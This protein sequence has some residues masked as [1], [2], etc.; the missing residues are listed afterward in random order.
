MNKRN[1][2]WLFLLM[3]TG[4]AIAIGVLFFFI[5]QQ[6]DQLQ[7]QL[8]ATRENTLLI[9]RSLCDR[10][11]LLRNDIEQEQALLRLK[12]RAPVRAILITALHLNQQTL[13]TL[14]DI[15]CPPDK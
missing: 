2:E 3:V 1:F 8:I 5:V 15:Q 7:R 13:V 11:M 12:Q 4:S 6:H 10:K 9:N 14:A